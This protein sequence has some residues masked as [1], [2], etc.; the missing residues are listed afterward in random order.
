MARYSQPQAKYITPKD[1]GKVHKRYKKLCEHLCEHN[2]EANAKRRKRTKYTCSSSRL[3]ISFF[4]SP[5]LN[6]Q[7]EAENIHNYLNELIRKHDLPYHEIGSDAIEVLQDRKP[8]LYVWA[9]LL[10]RESRLPDKVY[11]S[12]TDKWVNRVYG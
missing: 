1:V 2:V 3:S 5:S 9:Y 7:V 12:G 11:D 6:E 4:V 8:K 10:F